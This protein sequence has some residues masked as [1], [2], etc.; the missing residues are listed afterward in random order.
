[1]A[2]LKD[3]LVTGNL[4]VTNTILSSSLQSSIIR[5]PTTSNSSTYGA[6]E[7]GHVLQS[8]GSSIFWGKLSTSNIDGIDN[9]LLKT[10]GNLTGP[11][12]SNSRILSAGTSGIYNE[13]TNAL[14]YFLRGN[15]IDTTNKMGAI[16]MYTTTVNSVQ[17]PDC[18][19]FR[20]YSYN[21]TTNTPVESWEQYCLPQVAADRGTSKTYNI[22]TDKNTV[23]ILQGGTGGTTPA[24]ARANLELGNSKIFYGTCDTEAATDI[25]QVTCTDFTNNDLKVGAIIYVT[26]TQED[27]NTAAVSSLKLKVN[28]SEAKPIKYQSNAS[29][30]NL[31]AVGYIRKNITYPFFYDGTNWVALLNYDSNTNTLMRTY[32]LNTTTELPLLA[33]STSTGGAWADYTSSY[34]ALYGVISNTSGNRPTINPSTGKIKVPGGIEGNITGTASN[35]TGIVAVT[36][37]G[38]GIATAPTKGGIIYGNSTT[39]YGC[40]GAGT[41]GQLLQSNGVNAPTWIDLSTKLQDYVQVYEFTTQWTGASSL[42]LGTGDVFLPTDTL[43]VGPGSTSDTTVHSAIISAQFEFNLVLGNDNEYH[44]YAQAMGTAPSSGTTIPFVV[45]RTRGL[46]QTI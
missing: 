16:F 41:T 27:T 35:V 26:F 25:K 12:I 34:K 9:Y 19:Y 20:H 31:P 13:S 4:Q 39:E 15:T 33:G 5:A 11:L 37:G 7:D 28:N 24:E 36:N 44:L 38:T 29:T 18:F 43:I 42:E 3:T 45:V 10:G 23:T 30:S 17:V 14:F 22:L 2:Q 32:A 46:K 8:N 21:S 1:M 6:G 40:T